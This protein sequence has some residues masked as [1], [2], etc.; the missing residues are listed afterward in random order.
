DDIAHKVGKSRAAIANSLRLLDLHQRVQAWV[1]QGLLSVG[2]AKVLLG[3]KAPE[4]Q[5]LISDIVLRRRATVR[6]TERLVARQLGQI[7]TRRKRR[8]GAIIVSSTAIS[9]LE[10]RLQQ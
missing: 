2:H 5:L 7:K 8:S 9:D 3:L 4:E 10:N 1:V 6:S